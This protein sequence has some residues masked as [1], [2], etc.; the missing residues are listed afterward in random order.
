MQRNFTTLNEDLKLLFNIKGKNINIDNYEIVEDSIA[1]M[2]FCEVLLRLT[3]LIYCIEVDTGIIALHSTAYLA[4]MNPS[5]EAS[6][7]VRI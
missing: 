7:D 1:V 5:V 2:P 3:V 6:T 4:M